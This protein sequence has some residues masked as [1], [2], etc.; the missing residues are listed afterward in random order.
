MLKI[1]YTR[2]SQS[3][4]LSMENYSP[5]WV[6]IRRVCLE[7]GVDVSVSS[8]KTLTLPWWA[9]LA[10]R[11]SIRIILKKYGE[12][13]EIDPEASRLLNESKQKKSSYLN[14]EQIQEI[15]PEFVRSKLKSVGFVRELKSYQLR[16]VAK[17]YSLHAGATFS[18]PGAGKTTE[19]LALFYTKKQDDTKLLII[20]P[21][22]AFSTWEEQLELCKPDAP[23]IVRLRG[24]VKVIGELLSREPQMMLITYQQLLTVINLIAS[25]LSKGSVF[26]FLDE[27]HRIKRGNDGVTGKA[28]LNI[29]HIPDFKLIMSGTPMPNS[30]IDLVSQFNFLYPEVRTDIDTVTEFIKPIYVRTT[31]CELG[32]RIPRYIYKPIQ[33]SFRQRRLYELLRSEDARQAEKLLKASDRNRLRSMGKSVLRMLQLTSNPALLA[34]TDFVHNAIL[35]ELLAEGDSPK[36][37]YVCNK[38]RMNASRDRKTIIWSSFV[39]TVEL[40]A[41]R[42]RDIGADFIHGGVDAGS[43]EESD[44]REAKIKLFHDDR[45]VFVLVANP[46]AAG[47]GIS[48]HTVCHDAIYI[49][50]TYNAAHFLQ[51][52]DRIHRLGLKKDQETI[53]EIVYCQDS[54]DDS[55]KRRLESKINKMSEVLNDPSLKIQPEYADEEAFNEDD[56]M[57]FINHLK[58]L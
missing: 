28:V 9:F 32:L 47:E 42:L 8:E 18:V 39:D 33:M 52:V 17:L 56:I 19:A 15:S 36:L 10:C 26:V 40:I 6:E 7:N 3:A 25:Y 29:S 30:E 24:G 49:D 1:Q 38:A 13:L 46:A 37:K 45:N 50:R 16:N 12:Q 35:S 27:S 54:I 11:N 20:A 21:K 57:D 34:K 53:V 43:E 48:L 14:V 22:N 4:L 2:D 58:G 5:A 44:S 41:L 51:S 31:K 55:V 23:N